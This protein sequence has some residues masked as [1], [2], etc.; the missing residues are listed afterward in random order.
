MGVG[1]QGVVAHDR[2]QVVRR[3]VALG[4]AQHDEVVP[5]DGRVGRERLH[6]V[7]AAGQQRLVAEAAR[8]IDPD[9]LLGREGAVDLLHT[10]Q[11]VGAAQIFG[12]DDQADV[13]GVLDHVGDGLDPVL[14]RECL[15]RRES[16][17][18]VHRV[19]GEPRELELLLIPLLDGCVV[20]GGVVGRLLLEDVLEPG[21]GVLRKDVEVAAPQRRGGEE[22]G[23][24]LLDVAVDGDLR[25]LQEQEV[26]VGDN[27]VLGEVL[28]PN[29]QGLPGRVRGRRASQGLRDGGERGGGGERR[30]AGRGTGQHLA[31]RERRRPRRIVGPCVRTRSESGHGIVLVLSY[32]CA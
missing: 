17:C 6:H 23:E 19:V 28:G 21:P 27:L 14:L 20:G 5:R 32:G 7:A 18:V 16:L 25:L 2:G 10:E 26:H 24:V 1:L 12:R 30:R 4:V 29:S 31:A 15:G 9:E 13:G 8:A 22:R 11:P 3:R